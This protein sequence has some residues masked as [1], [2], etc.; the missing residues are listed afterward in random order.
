VPTK[1][2]KKENE[3]QILLMV[4]PHFQV[5]KQT[6]QFHLVRYSGSEVQQIK[7]REYGEPLNY[8]EI[9]NEFDVKIEDIKELL[10]KLGYKG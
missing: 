2:L 5:K 3:Y 9:A 1:I 6:Y 10:N 4:F 8:E 7:I